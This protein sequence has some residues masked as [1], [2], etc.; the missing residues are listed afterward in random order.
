MTAI[1]ALETQVFPPAPASPF[2][3]PG[4]IEYVIDNRF[5]TDTY[6]AIAKERS[7]GHAQRSRGGVPDAN[8]KQRR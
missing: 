3:Q 1:L 7:R 2:V 6:S 5:V 8:S 4:Q